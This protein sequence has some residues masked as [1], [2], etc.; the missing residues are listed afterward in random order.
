MRLQQTNG[1]DALDEKLDRLSKK[2]G[3]KAALVLDRAT[4]AILRTNG[5]ISSLNAAAASLTNQ[6]RNTSLTGEA[7]AA[8]TNGGDTQGLE[9]FAVKVWAWINA[10]SGLVEELDTEVRRR[11][12]GIFDHPFHWTLS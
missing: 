10:S 11:R 9:E 5:Q 2:P 7:P 1:Q 4:G 6:S 3:V 8:T 12:L